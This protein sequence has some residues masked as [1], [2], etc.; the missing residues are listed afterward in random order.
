ML[1]L[2]AG[3][4]SDL[5]DLLAFEDKPIQGG[6]R[7]QK[8]RGAKSVDDVMRMVKASLGPEA[9]QRLNTDLKRGE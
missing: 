7:N 1:E 8:G 9:W 3:Q 2:K 6:G 5:Y 4:I